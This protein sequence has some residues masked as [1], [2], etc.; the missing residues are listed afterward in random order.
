MTYSISVRVALYLLACAITILPCQAATLK[1][2]PQETYKTP[3]AAADAAQKG[4]H[5]LIAPGEYFDCAVWRVDDLVIA[6][7]GPGVVI[8]DKVCWGKGLFVIEG[9]NTTIRN[10]TLMRARVADENG[11]GIR[12]D[13]GDLTVDGVTFIDNQNGILAP[14]AGATITI[15][16][17]NFEKNGFCGGACSHGIYVG[18]AKLLRVDNSRFSGTKQGHSIKSRALRTEVIGCNITDG[19]D[20]TSSYLIDAPNGGSLVVRDD[21]LE[22]GPKSENHAAAIAIGEEGVNQ[23]TPEITVTNNTF[24]N[25]GDY[26]TALVWNVTATP[27]TLTGNKLSGAVNPLKGDGST[28]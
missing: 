21:T 4:D 5:I 26:K 13:Q 22:K 1:V 7:T 19:P 28:N 2:G 27:A 8:R 12:L 16:N 24:R 10:L 18:H 3:S 17:S 14:G 25:D 20:G 6:G 15:R 9:N 23:P 11:A